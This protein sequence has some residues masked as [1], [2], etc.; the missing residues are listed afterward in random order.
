MKYSANWRLCFI[1]SLIVHFILWSVLTFVVPL[2]DFSS[3]KVSDDA[4]MLEDLPTGYEGPGWGNGEGEG[5]GEGDGSGVGVPNGSPDGSMDEN[6]TTDGV[7]SENPI[8]EDDEAEEVIDASATDDAETSPIIADDEADAIAQFKEQVNEAKKDPTKKISTVMVVGRGTNGG[9]SGGNG[10]G[11]GK[12]QM[13]EPPI[14]ISYFFPPKDLIPYK[15][16]IAVAAFI[17]TDGNVYKTKIMRGSG[18][19]SYNE[20]AMSAARRWKFKPALDGNGEPMESR[21]IISIP[22]NKPNIERQIEEMVE[23]NKRKLESKRK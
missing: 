3:A 9:G 12:P 13:G 4:I 22:F 14:T 16:T 10:R 11:G 21:K 17:G 8:L 6:T 18:H 5:T 7:D 20:I 2:L 1:V 19:P 23:V 15:G